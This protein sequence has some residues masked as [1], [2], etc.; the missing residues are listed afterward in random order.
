MLTAMTLMLAMN[1]QA[2]TPLPY[3][4]VP[5]DTTNSGC[6][7]QWKAEC[8]LGWSGVGAND[9]LD[10][11][12]FTEAAV[13][14]IAITPGGSTA[15]GIRR[16]FDVSGATDFYF[17]F[18]AFV[19]GGGSTDTVDIKL[20]FLFKNATGVVLSSHEHIQ[21]VDTA[22]MVSMAQAVPINAAVVEVSVL[23][24]N[25]SS[26][27]VIA[28]TGLKVNT[29][30]QSAGPTATDGYYVPHPSDPCGGLIEDLYDPSCF[31]LS[32]DEGYERKE[33]GIWMSECM[34]VIFC[35]C[36]PSEGA[37]GEPGESPRPWYEEMDSWGI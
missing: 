36:E 32:C 21:T 6:D 35:W 29:P 3:F 27:T 1:A 23:A 28:G 30:G 19:I 11:L 7:A 17:T 26:T 14:V 15:N 25:A 24:E 37:G 18:P 12:E 16:D 10:V 13:S 2:A 4:E 5:G 34:Y 8:E 31:D 33:E 20:R 9:T 22:T